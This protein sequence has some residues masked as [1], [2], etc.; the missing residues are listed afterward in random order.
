MRVTLAD[1]RIAVVKGG[2]APRTEAA[3]LAAIRAAGAPAPAVL[4][5]ADD[6]LALEPLA[7]AGGLGAAWGDLGA[8]LRRLHA[9]RGDRYGWG[10]DYAF[11]PVAIPNAPLPDWPDFWAERRVL[12]AAPHVPADL[13]RRLEA[14]ARRLPDLLPARP[15]PALLHGDLWTGNVLAAGGRITGLID[16]ACY[17]GD[18]EADLA[19][20]HL[21]GRPG[22]AFAKAYGPLDPGW[23]ARRAA[24]ALWPALNHLRLFGAGYRGMV[25]GFLEAIGA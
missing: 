6:L 1:G 9:A 16:P 13:A 8:A 4:A 11:G 14:A 5:V 3:M 25:E 17:H 21:F 12:N 20:L 18:P 22:P 24:Y 23:E 19:M 2:P 15:A 10:E 7:D